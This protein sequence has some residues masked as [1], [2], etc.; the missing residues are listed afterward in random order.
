VAAD[1][2]KPGAKTSGD[3]RL[4]PNDKTLLVGNTYTATL[5]LPKNFNADIDTVTFQHPNG[6]ETKASVSAGVASGTFLIEREREFTF[7][8]KVNGKQVTSAT[9]ETRTA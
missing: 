8:F 1:K 2:N 5:Q 3:L 7:G 9:Y 4:T 6:W